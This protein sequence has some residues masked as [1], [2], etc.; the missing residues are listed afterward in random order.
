[1]QP[2]YVSQVGS[3]YRNKL[4]SM[5]DHVWDGFYSGQLRL[6]RFPTV[7]NVNQQVWDL[8]YTGT[9]AKKQTFKLF[10]ED[11]TKGVTI[12][13]AYPSAMSVSV[14]K[15]DRVVEYNRWDDTLQSY[16]P[17]KQTKCGEN[18]YI[19]VKNILEFYITGGC[20]IKIQPR[21]AIQTLVRMEWTLEDFYAKGGTTTFVDR[22]AGS[23][24]IHASTIK[25]VSVY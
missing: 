9:P 12:R 17:I 23:L 10:H 6:S 16:G 5:M 4:N 22:L 13:I 21:N 24:G 19:G 14:L 8:T 20:M 18:R 3:T 2:I 25:V 7:I 11:P 15:D 1:M